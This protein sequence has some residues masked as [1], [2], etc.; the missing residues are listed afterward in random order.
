MTAEAFR[1]DLRRS[2]GLVEAAAGV[3]VLG[4]RAPDFS[5][6][7]S[8]LWALEVIAEEGLRYDSSI[9]P[10]SGPR[11]GIAG[12][13]RAPCRV[14]C[15]ANADLIEFPLTTIECFGRR[16][17]AAGGGYFR[18][19]PYAYSRL[20]VARMNRDGYPATAYFH[21]YEL[22]AGE[23]PSLERAIPWTTRISQGLGRSGVAAKLDRL[24]RDFA[25][26]TAA[27]WLADLPSL[28]S[29]RVLDL[30]GAPE[31]PVS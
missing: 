11:Y 10:F 6:P 3:K 20:A 19:F 2:L 4:Y 27:Q 14:R 5:I 22:D 12:A 7:K 26:G 25:W 24:L 28:T 23:I 29:G 17:P 18:L 16:L 21:P 15:K 13:F 30:A 8:A 31:G 1:A 9:F